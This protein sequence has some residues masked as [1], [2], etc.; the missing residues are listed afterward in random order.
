MTDELKGYVAGFTVAFLMRDKPE[1]AE[2][3]VGGDMHV[4]RMSQIKKMMDSDDLLDVVERID[5]EACSILEQIPFAE[6][7]FGEDRQ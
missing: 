6:M 5:E 4:L 2:K 3:M 7:D 1:V